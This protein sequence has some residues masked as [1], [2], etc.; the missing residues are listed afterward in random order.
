MKT[1]RLTAVAS[2][3]TLTLLGAWMTS[4]AV[5]QT[6]AP[7]QQ[8]EIFGKPAVS[9]WVF[10]GDAYVA[11]V[12]FSGQ[13]TRAEVIAELVAW[14]AAGETVFS[15]DEWIR[16]DRFVSTASRAEVLAEAAASRARGDY[17]QVGDE[18]LPRHVAEQS[19][20][21]ARSVPPRAQNM[22]VLAGRPAQ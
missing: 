1:L 5:A 15:G 13:R 10:S 6:A 21:I 17:V 9:G 11:Y 4:S 7:A 3:L 12:P 14:Q 2:T 8:I 16:R 18:M 22:A 19:G 20:A